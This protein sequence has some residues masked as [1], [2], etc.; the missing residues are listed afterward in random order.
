MRGR[1]KSVLGE[2]YKEI[3]STSAHFSCVSHHLCVD[4]YKDILYSTSR[5]RVLFFLED[6]TSEDQLD[7]L[8]EV[9]L[10]KKIG[11]HKHIVSVLGS[12][13]RSHPICLI[14]EYCAHGD[15]QNFLRAARPAV[16]TSRKRFRSLIV[17]FSQ[18]LISNRRKSG[19]QL[20]NRYSSLPGTLKES[21]VGVKRHFHT[22]LYRGSGTDPYLD[23]VT[24]LKV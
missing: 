23:I 14:V 24:K 13:T 15:L 7:L 6:G 21:E 3:K 5:E 17:S 19:S 2:G 1:Q 18:W 4:A 16:E 8:K 22:S 10:M 20:G 12:I 9:R 11:Q